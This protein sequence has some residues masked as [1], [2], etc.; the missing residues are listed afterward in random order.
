MSALINNSI[1][2]KYS[3]LFLSLRKI[4]FLFAMTTTLLEISKW[5]MRLI[6]WF[7]DVATIYALGFY[8]YIYLM[9]SAQQ[10]SWG[11]RTIKHILLFH[12]YFKWN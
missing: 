9:I 7:N 4:Y 8:I 5:Q 2:K 3:L 10:S 1:K 6:K 11:W 12:N